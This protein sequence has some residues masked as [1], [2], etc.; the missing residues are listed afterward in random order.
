MQRRIYQPALMCLA[1]ILFF[2][3]KKTD[4]PV[5]KTQSPAASFSISDAKTWYAT[6]PKGG[7]VSGRTSAKSKI[8]KFEP[9]WATAK[10]SEDENYYIVESSLNFDK[11]PG[12][13][14]MLLL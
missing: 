14:I 9:D 11:A 3:C 8:R 2:G 13:S 12:F 4:Q 1:L 6:L 10:N 5:V 7:T